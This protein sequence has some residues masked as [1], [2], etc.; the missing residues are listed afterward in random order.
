MVRTW[1]ADIRPLAENDV[2]CRYYAEA[3]D[4]RKIKADRIHAKRGKMQSIGVWALYEKVCRQYHLSKDAVYNFSHSGDYVLCTVADTAGAGCDIEEIKS[5][6]MSVAKRFFCE[7][8]YRWIESQRSE[9]KQCQEFY[10][11][12]VLKES[13]MK[14]VRMGMKLPMNTYEIRIE[15][16]DIPVLSMK[17]IAICGEFYF[18]E[19]KLVKYGKTVPY[20]IAVCTTDPEID[21]ELTEIQL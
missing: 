21:A 1:I 15:T 14:A 7:S 3:P 20:R 18:R 5:L 10:R 19:Y 2:Y 4:F 8:E 13:F 12:W 11:F 9:E 6:R 17:P 16:D